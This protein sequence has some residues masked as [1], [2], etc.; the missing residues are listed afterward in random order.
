MGKATT[1]RKK[2][3]GDVESTTRTRVLVCF[4]LL[5][6]GYTQN[7]IHRRVADA[8][9]K[10]REGEELDEREKSLLWKVEGKPL[11]DRTVRKYCQL[12]RKDFEEI[13]ALK[14]EQALGSSL[15]RRE[16]LFRLALERQDLGTAR[17]VQNDIDRLMGLT[18]E[19]N[20]G[21][22]DEEPQGIRLPNGVIV[23]L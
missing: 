13:Q 16:K 17:L 23:L 20:P 21:A 18:N 9:R 1:K 4:A 11:A 7:E 14:R 5:L 10:E 3:K 2:G 6:D 19:F 8:C 15:A 12:A 22:T